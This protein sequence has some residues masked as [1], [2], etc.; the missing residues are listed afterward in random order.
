[1]EFSPGAGEQGQPPHP[2]FGGRQAEK[3]ASPRRELSR[4][5]LP[6]SWARVLE[7]RTEPRGKAGRGRWRGE[8]AERL[9]GRLRDWGRN[10]PVL[11]RVPAGGDL[12]CKSVFFW[13]L[14]F[15]S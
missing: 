12:G 1:M 10:G 8:E 2:V 9:Q 3:W 14:G 15:L 6:G 11:F 7:R 4:L 5:R 13:S